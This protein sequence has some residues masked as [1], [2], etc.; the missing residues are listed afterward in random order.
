MN[1]GYNDDDG[2]GD[3]DNDSNNNNASTDATPFLYICCI[4]I[5]I[6]NERNGY[7]TGKML[8]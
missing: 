7:D 4:D 8:A 5:I 1:L 3:D 6:H 2:N